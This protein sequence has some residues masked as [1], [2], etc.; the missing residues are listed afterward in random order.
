MEARLSGSPHTPRIAAM[1]N[2]ALDP[3]PAPLAGARAAVPAITAAAAGARDD[4]NALLD[5]EVTTV[6]AYDTSGLPDS[7]RLFFVDAVLQR[8]AAEREIYLTRADVG[9]AR[10][11]V[12][13][14]MLA[15]LEAHPG[16][17]TFDEAALRARFADPAVDAEYTALLDELAALDAQDEALHARHDT[18]MFDAAKELIDAA[19]VTP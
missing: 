4:N 7:A 16:A 8:I 2:A 18:L 6:E 13:E 9:V 12:R 5:A 19:G 15:F 10:A 3:D 14:R 11:D 1:F 17:Y